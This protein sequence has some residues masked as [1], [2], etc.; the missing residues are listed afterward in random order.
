MEQE[1][2]METI[3][4]ESEQK[5]KP[6]P[7]YRVSSFLVLGVLCLTIP[8]VLYV[9]SFY[10]LLDFFAF[11]MHDTFLES[12]FMLPLVASSLACLLP[13][14]FLIDTRYSF[15]ERAIRILEIQAF[16][17]LILLIVLGVFCV[18]TLSQEDAMASLLYVFYFEGISRLLCCVYVYISIRLSISSQQLPVIASKN[19]RIENVIAPPVVLDRLF[20]VSQISGIILLIL[21]VFPLQI[22]GAIN[23]LTS[24][25]LVSIFFLFFYLLHQMQ[26]RPYKIWRLP[27]MLVCTT[28]FFLYVQHENILWQVLLTCFYLYQCVFF[29]FLYKRDEHWFQ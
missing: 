13:P 10:A 19:A 8:L 5:T 28:I 4:I 9:F 6:S 29:Y 12:P 1:K 24:F 16:L 3:R 26:A 27:Y 2:P 22:F 14:V 11:P 7:F 17:F 15:L 23:I 25:S 20:F 18:Y 21:M